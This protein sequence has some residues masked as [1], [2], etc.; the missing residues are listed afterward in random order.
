MKKTFYYIYTL[1]FCIL[2]LN[3]AQAADPIV[4]DLSCFL[5]SPKCPLILEQT[6]H[7]E[8]E[9]KKVQVFLFQKPA[10]QYP[11]IDHMIYLG[12]SEQ[13]LLFEEPIIYCRKNF[14]DCFSPDT[15]AKRI[16]QNPNNLHLYYKTI[17]AG[18]VTPPVV[19]DDEISLNLDKVYPGQSIIVTV[20]VLEEGN[21]AYTSSLQFTC[22]HP[23]TV[24]SDYGKPVKIEDNLWHVT[25]ELKITGSPKSQTCTLTTVT[26]IHD[27]ANLYSDDIDVSAYDLSFDIINP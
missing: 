27:D 2:F 11:N 1:F 23:T 15:I 19:L 12:F 20:P 16:A 10:P 22:E 5:Q 9:I 18:D 6:H 25:Y 26:N 21:I 3:T 17:H 13:A 7:E 14:S 24:F 8:N 4:K